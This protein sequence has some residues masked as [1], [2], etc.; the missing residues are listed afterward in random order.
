MVRKNSEIIIFC[1]SV[2]AAAFFYG[3]VDAGNHVAGY[4]RVDDCIVWFALKI[5]AVSGDAFSDGVNGFG[6]ALARDFID[7]MCKLVGKA[8]L[9]GAV[10]NLKS[11]VL[12]HDLNFGA[13]N[14]G[15]KCEVFA[16]GFVVKTEAG[17]DVRVAIVYFQHRVGLV[18]ECVLIRLRVEHRGECMNFGNAWQCVERRRPPLFG[19]ER[20]T[21]NCRP[22]QVFEVFWVCL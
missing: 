6:H 7:V 14:A 15:G 3:W 21:L 13:E 22:I 8:V 19:G 16:A 12:A 5:Y 1:F 11:P 17:K 10:L 9:E 4:E 20:Y 18:V 2:D